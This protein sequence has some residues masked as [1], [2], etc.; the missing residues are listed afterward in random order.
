MPYVRFDSGLVIKTDHRDYYT[1]ATVLNEKAGKHALREQSAHYL[2]EIIEEV[3]AVSDRDPRKVVYCILRNV[4]RSGMSRHIDF[5]VVDGGAIRLISGP[6]AHVTDSRQ[7]KDGSVIVSGCG[8]DMGFHLVD[9]LERS[10]Y[11]DAK[12]G[13]ILRHE[14]L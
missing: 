10:L 7:A 11:P 4:S 14:W 9:W 13:S 1:D 3:A 2:R 8:M 6:V 5:A 12:S